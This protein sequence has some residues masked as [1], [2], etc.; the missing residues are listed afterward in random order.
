MRSWLAWQDPPLL[1]TT[2]RS[3]ASVPLPDWA[4]GAAGIARAGWLAP[5]PAAVAKVLDESARRVRMFL[6]EGT[7][8]TLAV[9]GGILLLALALRRE[10]RLRAAQDRFLAGATHELK[11]P[12]ATLRLGLQT[13][14]GGRLSAEQVQ[15]YAGGMLAQVDRLENRVADM[16]AAAEIA[17]ARRT[18]PREEV[19]LAEEITA[20]AAELSPRFAALGVALDVAPLPAVRA[21]VDRDG[22]RIALRNLLDNAAKYSDPGGK[23]TVGL[24][25]QDGR[26]LITV[27]DQGIGVAPRESE[28][29]FE[30]FYRSQSPQ[31]LTRGG[32]GL[33]LYLVREIVEQHGGDASC[34]SEGEGKGTTFRISVPVGDG[35]TA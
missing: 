23:V 2:D 25:R 26:A 22:I 24:L 19:D 34:E 16:L 5:Q 31:A 8:F 15:H 27:R 3:A 20:V 9:L 17:Q 6:W 21:R 10:V 28:R 13:I 11:T 1:L 4:P 18:R 33:G 29:I 7:T 12:V 32:A 30:R 35:G 14:A